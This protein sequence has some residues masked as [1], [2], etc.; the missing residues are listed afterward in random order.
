M[1]LSLVLAAA[2]AQ[3]S[4]SSGDGPGATLQVS[5]RIVEPCEVTQSLQRK[6]SVQDYEQWLDARAISRTIV[7]TDR[8]R[9]EEVVF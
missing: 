7:K 6:C 3:A 2:V 9:I 5:L 8:D 1:M 4:P